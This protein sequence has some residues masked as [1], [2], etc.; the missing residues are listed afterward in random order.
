MHVVTR[1]E[2]KPV[3]LI[4][5]FT[6]THRSWEPALEHLPDARYMLVDLPGHGGSDAARTSFIETAAQIAE[7]CGPATYVGYSMGGRVAMRIA[8]DHPE[9]VER[10]VC[11]GS[12][13]GIEDARERSLRHEADVR[14]ADLVESAGVE[15]FLEEWMAQPIFYGV[16]STS[17]AHRLDNSTEGIAWAM[18]NL[19]TGAMPPMWEHLPTISVPTVC[20]AG[21][22]DARYTALLE[23][24][25][26][27]IPHAEVAVVP[28]CGHAPHLEDPASFAAT[29]SPF[30][31]ST[32]STP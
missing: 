20:V 17:L 18:R 11:I 26:G 12:D 29:I 6:Q 24:V 32:S 14:W 30:L 9:V 22:R 16:P 4:H 1:G 21:E 27:L 5:G 19:G 13:P 25:A 23:R 15:K 7:E 3:V 31:T 10:L 8:I 2:G 28:G